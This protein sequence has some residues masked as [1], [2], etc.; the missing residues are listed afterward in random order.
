[1][2]CAH[3]LTAAAVLIACG[4]T[5]SSLGPK[6]PVG[7]APPEPPSPAVITGTVE[8]SPAAVLLRL[9]SGDIVEL[10]GSEVQRLAPL[11]G[12]QVELRG[13]WA[14]VGSSIFDTELPIVAV[15]PSFEVVEFLVLSIGGR[16]AMD[17]V[18]EKTEGSYYLRLAAGDVV[19]LADAPS[20]FEASI[21]RRIWV[22]GSMEDPPLTF[23]VID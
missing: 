13:E 3:L 6:Y 11:Y 1:M 16:P 4:C 12:A 17:G 18:L 15:R 7:G 5:E 20:A 9:E 8:V 19:L 22:T 14:F 2:K 23:G 10:V 21:G